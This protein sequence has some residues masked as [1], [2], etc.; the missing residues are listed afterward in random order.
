[1]RKGL[2]VII[3]RKAEEMLG[4]VIHVTRAEA[5]AVRSFDDAARMPN[6]IIG[7]HPED[8]DLVR[9]GFLEEDNTLT[10]DTEVILKGS[11]WAA[12]QDANNPQP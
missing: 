11:T 2:Y 1:M 12:A 3:D 6:S 4:N 8:F 9:L 10:V 7:Q 5:P